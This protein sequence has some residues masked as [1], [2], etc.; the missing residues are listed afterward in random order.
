M[1][2][3][4]HGRN[5]KIGERVEEYA[6]R[7]LEK[8]DRYLPNIADVRLEITRE[9]TRR[10]EDILIAQLTVRHSRGAIL[11]AEERGNG[12]DLQAVVN[13]TIDNM[14]R[15]IERFKGKRS[16]KGRTR[17]S[18]RFVLTVEEME[19]AEEIPAEEMLPQPEPELEFEPEVVRHKEIT[20]TP[21][22]E[23]EAIEQMELLGHSF[24][25]FFNIET[26]GVNVLYRRTSGD[27]G[28]LVPIV[29]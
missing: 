9:H 15:R 21:M 4:I 18:E 10:G 11:R 25:V 19:Q 29:S 13:H 8:L 3:Q 22:S 12:N 17:F 7:K 27:Y 1:E 26:N 14:Y 23:A 2:V 24:F 6:R 28:V 16:A 20:L 5:L